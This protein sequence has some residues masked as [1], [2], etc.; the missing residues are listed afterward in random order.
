MAEAPEA[1][2]D[3]R[4][5]TIRL[6]PAQGRDE[7]GAGAAAATQPKRRFPLVPFSQVRLNPGRN[8]LVKGIIPREGLVILWGP[9]KSGKSFVAFDITM[10]VAL[11]REYRG[12]RVTAGTVV[13][14]A[15]EGERGLGARVEAF[16]RA[17]LGDGAG[18][19]PFYL[20]TTRLDLAVEHEKLISEIRD[21][22]GGGDCTAIVIDTLNRSLGGSESSD[23]DMG[24]YVKAADATR[25]AFGC[26]VI[27]I[28]HC[29]LDDTRPRGH[30][31][32]MG[33]ADA[34]I[35]VKRDAAGL[36]VA[37]VDMMKDGE[38][39]AEIRSTLKVVTLDPDEDGE[40][41]TSCVI[42]PADGTTASMKRAGKISA[43]ARQALDL[44]HQ[45]MIE[46]TIPAPQSEHIPT[47][48]HGVTKSL[49]RSYCEKAGIIN[50][51]GNPR[52]QLRRIVVTLKDAG[53]IGV[54]DDFV[55]PVTTRH[56]AVTV[57]AGDAS[58]HVTTL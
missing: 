41:V 5:E 14:V 16:R 13:Y 27:V 45:A 48:V 3:A 50:A 32:L 31:S 51:E 1:V 58:R 29:G 11:G 8:Y 55:W 37:T 52:E 19:V 47:G 30:T 21:Q 46:S 57:T 38:T 33:A 39:G 49:W 40:P 9:P 4:G 10:H 53:L 43:A 20:L 34:Q 15:C 35:S 25:D 23:K 18:S 28:H 22:I 36:I 24:D 42:E 54:W 26:A 17:K 44:L 56:K 2:L 12:R 7:R 6:A